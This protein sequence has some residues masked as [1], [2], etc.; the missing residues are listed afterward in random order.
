VGNTCT[1]K[2]S[3]A[4]DST[5]AP[6]YCDGSNWKS[7]TSAYWG[8]PVTSYSSLPT[9]TATLLGSTRVVR[10]PTTGSGPR[11]YTCDGST[12]KAL[13]VDDS[14]NLSVP[15]TLT[16]G[17]VSLID[18]VTVGSACTTTGQVSRDSTGSIL[19]CQSGVW[20]KGGFSGVYHNVRTER[21]LGT[22]YQNSQGKDIWVSIRASVQG[23]SQC[24]NYLYVDGHPVA[25][26]A[27]DTAGMSIGLWATLSGWI[28]AGSTYYV[29]GSGSILA[30]YEYY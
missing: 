25:M 13:T 4:T 3:V 5:G 2:S 22:S 30:W 21:T 1:T 17:K 20:A 24:C 9:C 15:T 27:H 18:T 28:P 10:T 7:I 19:S 29:T 11:A 23:S 8:D 6:V 14:G 16:A 26:M 12:W